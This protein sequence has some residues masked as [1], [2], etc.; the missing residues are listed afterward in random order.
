MVAFLRR[1]FDY[2]II[3]LSGIF[4]PDFYAQYFADSCEPQRDFLWHYL[5]EGWRE[6]LNPSPEFNTAFYL[7]QYPD[8]RQMGINP[9]AHY[10]RKGRPEGRLPRKAMDRIYPRYPLW[11]KKF[12][13]LTI[14]DRWKIKRKIRGF[15]N[16]PAFAIFYVVGEIQAIQLECSL[17]S[18]KKQI[19]KNWNAFLFIRS[20][21]QNHKGVK[22]NIVYPGN[23]R[24]KTRFFESETD[25]QTLMKQI[26]KTCRAD[27][28]GLMSLGDVLSPHTFYLLAD[29]INQDPDAAV[30]YTDEDQLD[31]NGQRE[32]PYFKPDW[33]PDLFLSQ[34]FI[35][36]FGIF[37][38]D[39]VRSA[40]GLIIL[41]NSINDWDLAMRITE[42]VPGDMIHHIPFPLC[43]K[44]AADIPENSQPPRE[45]EHEKQKSVLENHIQRTGIRA[46]TEISR[47]GAY[48]ICYHL[49]TPAPKVTIIIPTRN[50]HLL[51]SACLD[52][53]RQH[54]HYDD[55]EI[56]IVDNGSDDPGALS[57]LTALGKEEKIKLLSY[58]QPFN[59]AAI[60]NFAAKEA[61]GEIILFMNNDVDVISENWLSELVSHAARPEIG[62]VGALLF[63][64][65]DTIQHAGVILKPDDIAGHI[66]VNEPRGYR[67]VRNRAEL[68]QNFSAVT[69]ACMA[70]E[71]VK[72]NQVSGF[73]EQQ[74]AVAYNDIDLCLRLIKAGYRNLWTPYA[75]LYHHES[76]SRG[77]DTEGETSSRFMAEKNVMQATWEDILKADPAYNPNLSFTD[78][79]CRLAFP[80]RTKKPWLEIS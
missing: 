48:R 54:T 57:Y 70:V 49:P 4:D 74:L 34:D 12:D 78:L 3:R 45:K 68:V 27:F 58:Q 39:L 22:Q 59:F 10:I 42:R 19:Y 26:L 28:L 31:R 33:N 65:Q 52:S 60:N 35:N 44:Y 55:Y 5:V 16:K 15:S 13:R 72:F 37:R 14:N 66:Y 79:S 30:L 29:A 20:N 50:E 51:L 38:M 36:D 17:L 2:V 25:L 71:K 8:V 18:L 75:Q 77:L 53:I 11:I 64:P 46:S 23:S 40:D 63:Y 80:P 7:N 47:S 24:I 61:K 9:L 73:N 43:H 1:I 6:G 21:D 67:G 56:I 41:N 76:A 69:A 32:N 62:A